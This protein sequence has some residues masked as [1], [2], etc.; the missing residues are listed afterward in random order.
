MKRIIDYFDRS[1]II[2]LEDRVDRRREV[3]REFDRAGMNIPNERVRFY[4]AKRP[5]DKGNFVTLGMRG[6]F[7]SHLEVLED[8]QRDNLRNVLVFEDD[9]SFR[10]IGVDFQN[11]LLDDLSQR[12]WDLLWLG[13]LRPEDVTLAGPLA[14]WGNDI[15]G[16]HTYAVNGPFI[17]AM[18]QYMQDCERRPRDHP[19]GGPMPADGAYNHVRYVNNDVVLLLAVPQLTLQRNSRSDLTPNLKVDGNKWIKPFAPFARKIKHKI[20]M[21][22]DKRRLREQLADHN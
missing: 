18:A 19:D 4:T 20:R 9:V 14:R 16:A 2:N 21:T 10:D 5:T 3:V 1:Y 13:Y 12:R 7:T 11:R 8:A 6:C 17:S 22:L 15:L